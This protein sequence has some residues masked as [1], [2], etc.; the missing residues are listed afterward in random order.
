MFLSVQFVFPLNGG[1]AGCRTI[2]FSNI[3]FVEHLPRRKPRPSHYSHIYTDPDFIIILQDSFFC[4]IRHPR[5]ALL[6]L[7]YRR[8]LKFLYCSFRTFSRRK[9]SDHELDESA[10]LEESG[11]DETFEENSFIFLSFLNPIF[12]HFEH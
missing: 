10:L 5:Q 9:M 8:R 4:I 2:S 7:Y 1:A 12:E 11:A 3:R 6:K